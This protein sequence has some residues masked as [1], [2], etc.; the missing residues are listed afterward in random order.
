MQLE[1][2]LTRVGAE[3]IGEYNIP[4]ILRNDKEFILIINDLIRNAADIS[5]AL[6]MSLDSHLSG[7][8]LLAEQHVLI[9][10]AR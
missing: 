5:K 3:A 6:F 2:S 8:I 1:G 10:A 7:K 4:M 9:A